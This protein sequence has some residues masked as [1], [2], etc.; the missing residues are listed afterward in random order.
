MNHPMN[1]AYPQTVPA[2]ADECPDRAAGE[3]QV[4]TR[5][6]DTIGRTPLLAPADEMRL[7]KAARAGDDDASKQLAEANLRLVVHI[8][9]RYADRGVSLRDLIAAGN[10]GLMR[11]VQTFEARPDARFANYAIW[12]IRRQI[13][14]TLMEEGRSARIPLHRLPA[15]AQLRRARLEYLDAHGR[16]PTPAE[17]AD[18]TGIALPKVIALLAT[19]VR[20]ASLQAPLSKDG[21]GDATLGDVIADRDAEAPDAAFERRTSFA[22]VSKLLD[23]LSP[24][25][26]DI[27]RSRFG[28]EDG[29]PHT[30][31]E[32]GQRY[33]LTR[34]R[35]R[36][37]QDKAL[38]RLRKSFEKLSAP[39]TFEERLAE[40][41]AAARD[42]VFAEFVAE[43]RPVRVRM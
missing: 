5:Y 43:R 19:G 40:K 29:E 8:A 6:L 38:R 9:S 28:L 25:E 42:A 4:L 18:V 39:S 1:D 35:V 37:I 14:R 30:C 20:P 21:D 41:L 10:M 22:E 15:L 16:E 12:W 13:L 32:I 3:S 33:G 34:E 27:L 31:E 26:A 11:A 7:S 2:A 36:Q 17:L 24:R 23:G